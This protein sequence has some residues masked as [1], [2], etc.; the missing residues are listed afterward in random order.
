[1]CLYVVDTCVSHGTMTRGDVNLCH[2]GE[3]GSLCASPSIVYKS[4]QLVSTVGCDGTAGLSLFYV[5]PS[6]FNTV[7]DC[8][9]RMQKLYLQ[10]KTP[11]TK[12]EFIVRLPG[13]YASSM[14]G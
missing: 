14:V 9:R 12:A 3:H 4:P 13:P 2:R 6:Y 11:A 7:S 5:T 1:M 10:Q 8:N